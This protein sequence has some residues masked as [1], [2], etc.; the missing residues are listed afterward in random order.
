[1][2][3]EVKRVPLKFEWPLNQIWKGYINPFYSEHSRECPHCRGTGTTPGRQ[4]LED[5]V[6]LLMLS[7]SDAARQKSHPYFDDMG[8]LHYSQGI[9]PSKDLAE[10]TTGLAGRE[11]CFIGHDAC[12]KWS[13]VRK[14]ILAAGIRKKNWGECPHCKGTGRLWDSRENEV[15]SNR[16]RR[17]EPPKGA[18]YQIW[19]TVSEGSPISPVFAKPEDLADWMATPGHGWRT[20]QGTS[21]DQWLAFIRGPGWASSLVVQNGKVMSGVEAV[22]QNADN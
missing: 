12:D 2:G 19:E 18:G 9:I 15:A 3:R 22:S 13:A 20:D 16:W 5:L 21:R 14:I 6:S 1:M 17:K 8:G 11:P 10:L 7:G 4:R